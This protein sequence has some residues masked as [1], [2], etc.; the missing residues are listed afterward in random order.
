[1]SPVTP[2]SIKANIGLARSGS[3]IQLGVFVI[4]LS[5]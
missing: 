4:T 5:A 1:M 3:P 2:Q